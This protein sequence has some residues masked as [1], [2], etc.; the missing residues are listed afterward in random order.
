MSKRIDNREFVVTWLNSESI[1]EVAKALGRSKGAVA[2]KATEL[3]K[4]GVQVP[5]FTKK[6][7]E[8]AQKLEVA[9]LNSLINKHQKEGR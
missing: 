8:T 3:R 5:K 2:A 6:L 4:R 7:S 1:E 9:Q